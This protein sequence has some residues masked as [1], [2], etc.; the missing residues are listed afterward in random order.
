MIAQAT[1]VEHNYLAKE[2][3]IETL[4]PGEKTEGFVYFQLPPNKEAWPKQWTLHVESLNVKSKEIISL[5]IPF[6]WRTE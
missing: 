6:S 5:A 4:A 3:Q 2:F 1:E